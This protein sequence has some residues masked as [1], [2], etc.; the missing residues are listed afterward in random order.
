MK[1]SCYST[2]GFSIKKNFQ[3]KV[4]IW[5]DKPIEVNNPVDKRIFVC[6]EPNEISRINDYLQQNYKDFHYI[7]TYDESLLNN[8]P[9]TVL[10]EYGTTWINDD[11]EFREKENNISFVCN[12]KLYCKGHKMRQKIWHNQNKIEYNK[13]FFI[14]TKNVPES[15]R[16]I[17]NSLE[18][19]EGNLFLEDCKYPLFNSMFHLCIENIS[20][21]Y[22][23]T[24]KIIDCFLTKTIPI[25]W[26]CTNIHEYFNV[27]GMILFENENDFFNKVK[28]INEDFYNSKKD[29]IEEN[30]EKAKMWIDYPCRLE[31]KLK[32]LKIN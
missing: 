28:N 29:I 2:F 1:A 18:T 16:V 6:I 15:L 24:E 22:F 9:N 30:Y 7:L 4:E 12:N 31:N 20:K 17:T 11:F 26:G 13:K 23:F 8:L 27:N 10:F 32:E 14:G 19:Y 25:Y 5:I 3:E 21:K